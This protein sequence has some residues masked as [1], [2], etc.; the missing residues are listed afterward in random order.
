MVLGVDF[1]GLVWCGQRVW[2]SWALWIRKLNLSLLHCYYY[3]LSPTSSL[4]RTKEGI[5][6]DQVT[7]KNDHKLAL[8]SSSHMTTR[9]GAETGVLLK[10]LT[11]WVSEWER[12]TELEL[13][14]EKEKEREWERNENSTALVRKE[15]IDCS[16]LMGL[17]SLLFSS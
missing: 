14:L 3:I 16:L 13:E 12:E 11:E 2:L 9:I 7:A 17:L 10:T 1:S 15:E 6:V 4:Q 5:Q 8:M